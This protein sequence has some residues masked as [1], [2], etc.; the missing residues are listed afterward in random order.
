[1]QATEKAGISN[2]SLPVFSSDCLPHKPYIY[3]SK[4]F[5]PEMKIKILF[6]FL[7]AVLT[8]NSRAQSLVLS[9]FSK[10]KNGNA[11]LAE[12]GFTHFADSTTLYA[13]RSYYSNKTTGEELVV[14]VQT[15]SEGA[16]EF[17]VDYFVKT[18]GA[19]QQLETAAKNGKYKYNAD[20]RSYRIAG[21]TYSWT[22]LYFL[23]IE[24]YR[25]SYYFHVRYFAFT[26]KE[27][28]AP[29]K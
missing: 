27:L 28:S 1:M 5:P 23:G 24:T 26:G 9:D 7:L 18:I 22:D 3:S 29:G 6:L 12:K 13:Q 8:L 11:F 17:T 4:L 14:S 15:S 16:E 2:F 25:E 19:Y 10:C 20:K 21:S